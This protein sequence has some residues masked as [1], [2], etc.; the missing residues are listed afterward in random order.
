[1]GAQ[2][3]R[4]DDIKDLTRDSDPAIRMRLAS[5]PESPAEI[6]Y[7]LAEDTEIEV[8]RAV[9]E[10][11]ATP[12]QADTLLSR[13]SDYTVRC[14]LARKV[15]G[16]GLPR[17]ERSQ[18]WR[19]GFTILETL[20]RDRLVR[21][22]QAL[23]LAIKGEPSAPR[24]I[25]LQ[26]AHDPERDVASPIL[27]HSPV[28]NDDDLREIVAS[29]APDWAKTAIAERDAIG[30]DVS[31]AIID[32]GAVHSVTRLLRNKKAVIDDGTIE[33]VVD[34][35]EEV[36]EWHEPL[37]TR[38]RLPGTAIM[39][40]ARFVAVTLV[41]VLRGRTGLDPDVADGL[42]KVARSRGI[43]PRGPAA[44]KSTPAQAKAADSGAKR[45]GRLFRQ[46]ELSDDAVNLA[47]E[48]GDDDFIISALALR[49]GIPLN[50]AER[51]LETRSPRTV[52]ALCWKAGLSM[53]FALDVQKRISRI[54]PG[55]LLNARDGRAYPMSQD[56]MEFQLEL[57]IDS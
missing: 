48:T 20:A 43:E 41:H 47:L 51:V 56:E 13:D 28:L 49:A 22:R 46:G 44:T 50:T 16:Q 10:N 11:P 27:R 15:V 37:V 17:D 54:P 33:R 45:A 26:L 21:V 34:D 40:L 7:F 14:L 6:L 52:T 3:A 42:D 25:I 30:A 32:G 35:A 5:N 39:K 55:Q 36:V 18:L 19:L 57:V 53:R 38:P 31:R 1:M 8:R 23:A 9:A 24:P 4:Y 29:D 12:R 2:E